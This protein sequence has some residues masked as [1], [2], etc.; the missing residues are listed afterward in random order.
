MILLVNIFHISH[1]D[2]EFIFIYE[3]VLFVFD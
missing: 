2:V 1:E 3:F